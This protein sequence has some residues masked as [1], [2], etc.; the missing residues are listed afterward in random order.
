MSAREYT[1]IHDRGGPRQVRA[2]Q[3]AAR[4]GPGGQAI[5][6]LLGPDRLR[7]DRGPADRRERAP[8]EE[9]AGRPLQDRLQQARRARPTA[10]C[11]RSSDRTC[12]TAWSTST[13]SWR[14]A[15]SWEPK[16][17]WRINH[18][19]SIAKHLRAHIKLK[20]DAGRGEAAEELEPGRA[21]EGGE[22]EAD[23]GQRQPRR[24]R[25]DAQAARRLRPLR[26]DDTARTSPSP[27]WPTSP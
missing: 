1:P 9:G 2:R 23:Q 14:C 25:R 16:E 11:T 4:A 18:P 10:R 7:P 12:S 6:R 8:P 20:Q 24:A 3:G 13:T 15:R 27:S 26:P 19:N 5:R 17:R 22:G 21:A